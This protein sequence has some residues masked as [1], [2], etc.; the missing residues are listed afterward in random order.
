MTPGSV[1]RRRLTVVAGASLA[2][3]VIVGAWLRLVMAGAPLPLGDFGDIR[4]L[5]THLGYYGVL[6]PL[7]W[8]AWS[9]LGGPAPGPRGLGLYAAAVAVSAVGFGLDGYGPVAIAGST[10]VLVGWVVSA[11]ALWR[12]KPTG[13]L[14]TV[15]VGVLLG[16]AMVPWVAISAG[17]PRASEVARSFLGMLLLCALT[18]TALAVIRARPFPSLGWLLAGAASALSL[19]AIVGPHRVALLVVGALMGAAALASRA[20]LD[21]KVSWL[22]TAVPLALVGAGALPLTEQLAVAGVHFLVLGPLL[23]SLW[24]RRPGP[25]LR[26]SYLGLLSMMCAAILLQDLAWDPRLPSLAAAAGTG[27]ALSWLV[28]LFWLVWRPAVPDN[29]ADLAF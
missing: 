4:H 21:L 25:A 24:P 17:G 15:P 2:V 8:A 6:F 22:A 26:W 11:W 23:G 10:A 13:W 19:G 3:T 20:A 16:S 5:H 18:P 27:V 1:S 28:W 7:M 12:S 29:T 14:S 9:R